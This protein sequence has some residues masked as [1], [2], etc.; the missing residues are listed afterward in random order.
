LGVIV[1]KE[2][3]NWRLLGD[4]EPIINYFVYDSEEG[5]GKMQI[6]Q[7]LSKQGEKSS[8]NLQTLPEG[9][10]NKSKEE[11]PKKDLLDIEDIL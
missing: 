6:V 3:A 11:K 2:K 1:F 9:G 10:A 8:G 5:Y 4:S 7:P